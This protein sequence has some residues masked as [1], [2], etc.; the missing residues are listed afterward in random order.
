[1]ED[2]RW[3]NMNA[4]ADMS[5]TLPTAI[6]TTVSPPEPPGKIYPKTGSA[7]FVVL[8]RKILKN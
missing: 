4:P 6:Q 8:P 5:M 1:M 3:T 7:P 2:K